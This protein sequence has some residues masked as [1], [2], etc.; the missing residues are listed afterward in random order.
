MEFFNIPE[1]ERQNVNVKELFN[2]WFN[3]IFHL[4]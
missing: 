1:V 4:F 2:Q 3:C